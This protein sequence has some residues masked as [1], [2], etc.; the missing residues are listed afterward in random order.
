MVFH[1]NARKERA[2]EDRQQGILQEFNKEFPKHKI[3]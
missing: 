2:L 3:L 1:E